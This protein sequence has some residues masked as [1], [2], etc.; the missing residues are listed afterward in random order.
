MSS[1]INQLQLLQ[2]NLQ[3][4][5]IQKQQL[6]NQLLEIDSALQSMHNTEKAYKILGHIMVSIPAE[7]L[8]QE[9][10]EKKEVFSLRLKNFITQEEK[11]KKNLEELQKEAVKEL[12][13]KNG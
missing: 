10:Q 6:Q 11:L 5:Q 2:Q 4:T 12:G 7:K 9:L 8:S 13:T 3:N 1:A